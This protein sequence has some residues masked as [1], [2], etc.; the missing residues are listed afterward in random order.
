MEPQQLLRAAS[1][2]AVARLLARP[3]LQGLAALATP[4]FGSLDK[5]MSETEIALPAECCALCKYYMIGG[6]LC[7]RYPPQI[8]ITG[9]GKKGGVDYESRFPPLMP[10]GWCGEFKGAFEE[11]K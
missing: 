7:R 10:V 3:A 6:S 9:K 5:R 4:L 8:I 2:M 11:K 1:D